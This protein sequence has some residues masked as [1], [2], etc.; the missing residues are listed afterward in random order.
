M[1]AM[2]LSRWPATRMKTLMEQSRSSGASDKIPTSLSTPMSTSCFTLQESSKNSH[3]TNRCQ[4][5]RVVS[6]VASKS[7]RASSRLWYLSAQPRSWARAASYRI[8]KRAQMAKRKI[9]WAT[10]AR[11]TKY[12]RSLRSGRTS[13]LTRNKTLKTWCKNS[14][15]RI[16]NKFLQGKYSRNRKE[17]R[18]KCE[19]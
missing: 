13:P 18:T 3:H 4:L 1:I 2:R 5:E 10:L 14:W 17:L 7:R 9:I 11:R 15:R 19:G 12:A 16:N 6:R 8:P